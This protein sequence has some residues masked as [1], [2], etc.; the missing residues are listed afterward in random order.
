MIHGEERTVKTRV[1]NGAIYTKREKYCAAHGWSDLFLSGG[2]CAWEERHGKCTS[3]EK[4]AAIDLEFPK[5]TKQ[6]A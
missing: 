6:A 5:V 2:S 3:I 1:G 4:P